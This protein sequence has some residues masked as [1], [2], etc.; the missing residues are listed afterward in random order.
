MLPDPPSA[1]KRVL[2]SGARDYCVCMNNNL[3]E[4][5]I[6]RLYPVM[7]LLPGQ[8]REGVAGA[9]QA[10]RGTSIP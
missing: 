6:R 8:A 7:P 2:G 9:G 3:N 1:R 5:V 4:V 10:S